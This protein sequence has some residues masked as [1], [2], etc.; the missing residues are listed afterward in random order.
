MFGVEPKSTVCGRRCVLPLHVHDFAFRAGVRCLGLD[1]AYTGV[2][3]L[4]YK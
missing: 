1:Y 3:F 4:I 2:R